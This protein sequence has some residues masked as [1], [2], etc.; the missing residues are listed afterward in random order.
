MNIRISVAVCTHN[1]ASYLRKAIRSL[2]AQTL[3]PSLFEILII[4]NASTDETRDVI[5]SERPDTPA[6]RYINVPEVGVSHARN[7]GWQ[8]ARAK[9]VAYLDDDAIATPQ[10]LERMLDFLE[11]AEPQ[12]GVVGGKIEPIW[13]LP[14]PA[15]LSDRMAGAL[16]IVNWSEK[17]IIMTDKHWIA[18]A[19]IGFP[20][21]VLEE[22]GGFRADL[23]R[24][25]SCL[26]SNEEIFA[27]LQIERNG[28]AC[29]YNPEIVVEHH[30][31]ASRVNQSWFKRRSYWQG[32]SET[33]MNKDG[34]NLH[35]IARFAKGGRS[36]LKRL[37]TLEELKLLLVS[38]ND[39][40]RFE[41]KCKAW[42]RLGKNLGLMGLAR[43]SG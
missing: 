43:M 10:W 34:F 37:F 22:I 23:G 32:I 9:Y 17:P 1:R 7:A 33:V 36:L 39:P 19:N 29:Y 30:V 35:P 8:N 5:E 27:R 28:H 14:R 25:G 16:S 13:E 42:H 40:K 12:P 6:Y 15:W 18:A 31:H 2:L 38:T 20:R 26:L 21:S 11:N 41:E 4:D 24:R 3:D